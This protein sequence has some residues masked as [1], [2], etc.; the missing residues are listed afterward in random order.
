MCIHK[1]IVL[2]IMSTEKQ[3]ILFCTVLMFYMY[4]VVNMAQ[5]N[6]FKKS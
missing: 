2:R 4:Y 1:N 3:E 5:D 6:V